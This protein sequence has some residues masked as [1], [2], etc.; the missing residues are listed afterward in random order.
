MHSARK[1]DIFLKIGGHEI[2]TANLVKSCFPVVR[3]DDAHAGTRAS[4]C[5]VPNGRLWKTGR[6]RANPNGALNAADSA[7][8]K[9]FPNIA[10]KRSSHGRNQQQKAGS[11]G[12]NAGRQ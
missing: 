6:E 1:I 4:I 2:T 8:H 11:V 9:P 5:G 10:G 7:A 12:K 3:I